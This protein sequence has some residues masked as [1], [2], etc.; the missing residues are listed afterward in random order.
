MAIAVV[1]VVTE[2]VP[3]GP[4]EGAVNVTVM[5]LLGVPFVVTAAT[6]ADP[7]AAL[8]AWLWGVPLDAVIA[9]NGVSMFGAL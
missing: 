3:L 5:P 8:I 6:S 7:N 1:E 2:N 4:V 9:T